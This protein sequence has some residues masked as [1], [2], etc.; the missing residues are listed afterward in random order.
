[1]H[2]ESDGAARRK[3]TQCPSAWTLVASSEAM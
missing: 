1:M 3:V 2:R